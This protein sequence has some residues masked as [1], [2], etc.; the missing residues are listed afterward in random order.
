MSGVEIDRIDDDAFRKA[1]RTTS[2]CARVAPEHKLR[3]ID[4]LQAEGNVVS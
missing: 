3:I 2:V 4:A 1:V